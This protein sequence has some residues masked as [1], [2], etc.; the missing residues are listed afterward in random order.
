M[1]TGCSELDK[2][3][4]IFL[5]LFML[6]RGTSNS[7]IDVELIATRKVELKLDIPGGISS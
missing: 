7:S 5:L 3:T 1:T 6:R 2:L 4:K